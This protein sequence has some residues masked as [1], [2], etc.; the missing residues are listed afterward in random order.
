MRCLKLNYLFPIPAYE[1]VLMFAYNG[2]DVAHTHYYNDTRRSKPITIDL[3]DVIVIYNPKHVV[4]DISKY[5][6]MHIDLL[7]I[8]QDSR[9]NPTK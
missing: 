9:A 3:K 6:E 2:V 5:I 8:T 1:H 4:R 7:S